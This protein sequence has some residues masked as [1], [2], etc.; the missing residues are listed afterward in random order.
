M[1]DVRLPDR[2]HS[3]ASVAAVPEELK[4]QAGSASDALRW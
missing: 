3:F 4:G 2:R 1:G